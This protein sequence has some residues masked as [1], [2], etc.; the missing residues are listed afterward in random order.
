MCCKGVKDAIVEDVQIV[1]STS[2]KVRHENILKAKLFKNVYNSN[3]N[4]NAYSKPSA[5]L[6]KKY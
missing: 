4:V 5:C 1:V 2:I 6:M 3:V